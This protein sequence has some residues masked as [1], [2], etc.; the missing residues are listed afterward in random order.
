MW[1][2]A[3]KLAQARNSAEVQDLQ[4]AKPVQVTAWLER[5]ICLE[6]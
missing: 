6:K 4:I 5:Q 3:A 1:E 2:D